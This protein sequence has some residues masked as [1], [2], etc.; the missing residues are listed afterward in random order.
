MNLGIIKGSL[1]NMAG[2]V[3]SWAMGSLITFLKY[4]K[5]RSSMYDREGGGG[6][7]GSC[8]II[9]MCGKL[10]C[11]VVGGCCKTNNELVKE[12]PTKESI[13]GAFLPC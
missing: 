2:Q 9:K 10:D 7:G 11:V 13:E 12:T 6:G 4:G 8:V 3:G 5:L 1:V